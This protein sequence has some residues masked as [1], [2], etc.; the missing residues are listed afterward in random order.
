MSAERGARLGRLKRERG[1]DRW[2]R[3]G[4]GETEDR[5]NVLTPASSTSER[6]ACNILEKFWASPRRSARSRRKVRQETEDR[7]AEN[8]E[9]RFRGRQASRVVRD[10]PYCGEISIE[11]GN[12]DQ[13]SRRRHAGKGELGRGRVSTAVE[14][15]N[16]TSPPPSAPLRAILS[17]DSLSSPRASCMRASETRLLLSDDENTLPLYCHRN[18]YRLRA[19]GGL[20]GIEG[21]IGVLFPQTIEASRVCTLIPRPG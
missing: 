19:R 6:R 15:S 11:L 1:L 9:E 5:R 7:S 10:E 21:S 4:G 20:K 16:R 3:R 12:R 18:K 2:R 14:R 8:I 13:K 17:F